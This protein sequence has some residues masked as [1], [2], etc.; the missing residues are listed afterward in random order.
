MSSIVSVSVR[1]FDMGTSEDKARK[2]CEEAMEFY[3]A[4]SLTPLLDN[5]FLLL[6]EIGDLFT[7]LINY[8]AQEGIDPQYCIDLAETKNILRGR[9][10]S[11]NMDL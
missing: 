8:C 2:V 10:D 7:I 6:N 5:N 11:D 1:T 3:S 4:H 9:Y